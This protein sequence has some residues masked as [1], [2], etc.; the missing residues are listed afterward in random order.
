ME[1]SFLQSS[2]SH[3]YRQNTTPRNRLPL[4]WHEFL[5]W[6]SNI[7]L[8]CILIC[9]HLSIIGLFMSS[10]AAYEESTLLCHISQYLFSCGTFG[11][12][13]GCI[14]YLAVTLFFKKIPC[15]YGSGWAG[16][17]VIYLIFMECCIFRAFFVNH[18]LQLLRCVRVLLHTIW[19]LMDIL[20][21]FLNRAKCSPI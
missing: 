13:G 19:W 16:F 7:G 6:I 21:L 14:N 10:L 15:L 8:A 9:L 2:Y 18:C 20:S 17:F 1:H 12:S 3:V 11:F 4:L 5:R